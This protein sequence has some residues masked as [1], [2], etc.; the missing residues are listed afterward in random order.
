L[1]SPSLPPDGVAIA[2]FSV[3]TSFSL[4]LASLHASKT[5]HTKMITHTLHSPM[6]FF[7][8]T[9]VGTTRLLRILILDLLLLLL[10]LLLFPTDQMDFF[11]FLV[12][13]IA[14]L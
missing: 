12:V 9:P 11:S 5:I 13:P 14:P 3:C 1:F 10:L 4:T 8:T 2:V 6:A 7:D